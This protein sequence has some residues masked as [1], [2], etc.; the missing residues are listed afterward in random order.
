[1]ANPQ[2]QDRLLTAE[3]FYELPEPEEGGKVEL[4]EGRVVH[5]MPVSSEHGWV[6][7]VL[8]R[9]L[10]NFVVEH[11]LGKLL[12]EAGFVL[13]R[14]PDVVLAPDLSFVSRETISQRTLPRDGFVPYRPDLAIEIVSPSNAD[15]DIAR[16]VEE[17]QRAGVP[18]VWIVR[19]KLRTVTIHV[20]DRTSRTL[21]PG[22][23]LSSQDAGFSRSGF[24]LPL[25]SLFS[26]DD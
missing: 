5:E 11:A 2:V 15:I 20:P 13:R 3:E 10:G 7:A 16:K 23:A 25:D 19:P 18:F 8:T 17:Y 6:A 14:Q 22:S 12:I 24:A 1:M 9:L 26:D 4:I 21:L